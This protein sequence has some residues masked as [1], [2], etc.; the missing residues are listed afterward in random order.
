MRRL[1][2]GSGLLALAL[3]LPALAAAPDPPPAMLRVDRSMAITGDQ[4]TALH[5]ENLGLVEAVLEI[6]SEGLTLLAPPRPVVIPPAGRVEI[7]VQVPGSCPP[8]PTD[9]ATTACG[10]GR[11][12]LQGAGGA[13]C[14]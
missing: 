11:L 2:A 13:D 6:R 14:G 4:P 8:L 5:L 12:E 7:P 1:P 3:S 9:L 10:Q